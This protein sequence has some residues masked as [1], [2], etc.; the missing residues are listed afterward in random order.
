[1]QSKNQLSFVMVLAGIYKT[2]LV[3]HIDGLE[4]AHMNHFG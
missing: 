1:M 4:S 2:V 3:V